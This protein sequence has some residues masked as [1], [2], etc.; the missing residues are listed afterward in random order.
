MN[1]DFS[2]AAE[3]KLV[4]R[5]GGILGYLIKILKLDRTWELVL[6]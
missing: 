5:R 1:H 6:S 4:R 3:M 2:K